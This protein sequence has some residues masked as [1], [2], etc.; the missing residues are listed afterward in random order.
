MNGEAKGERLTP[1]TRYMLCLRMFRGWERLRTDVARALSLPESEVRALDDAA[2]PVVRLEAH[3]H[4]RGFQLTIDLFVDMAR[5]T[6]VDLGA[7][8]R[9]LAR[10][11]ETDVAYHRGPSPFTYVL[12]RS[13]GEVF[14]ADEAAD[15]DSDGLS[16]DEAS[17][18]LRR[19]N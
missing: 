14:I 10:L 16:L 7:F 3:A 8:A 19:L 13:S 1:R 6:R 2:D 4:V 15:E 18:R 17:E 5:M 12:V 9:A 11:N